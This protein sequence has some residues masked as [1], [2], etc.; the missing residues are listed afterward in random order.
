VFSVRKLE[1]SSSRSSKVTF[2][3]SR[4]RW[5]PVPLPPPVC[6]HKLSPVRFGRTEMPKSQHAPDIGFVD[7]L[8]SGDLCDS[9]VGRPP[10]SRA[11]GTPRASALTMALSVDRPP[12]V[13]ARFKPL[14]VRTTLRPPRRPI[15]IGT[16]T[17]TVRPSALDQGPIVLPSVPRVGS[18]A[19][20][21][22]NPTQQQTLG[23]Q[24]DIC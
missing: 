16:R 8:C 2:H 22:C 14:G 13:A 15:D 3:K 7:F 21:I 6:L 1:D 19:P 18:P 11:S 17:V 4:E 12:D 20:Y 23:A 9:R 10:A 24:A 5:N